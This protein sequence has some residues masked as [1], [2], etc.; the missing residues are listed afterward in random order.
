MNKTFSRACLAILAWIAQ[1]CCGCGPD[2]SITVRK[3]WEM[4]VWKTAPDYVQGSAGGIAI[5][6]WLPARIFKNATSIDVF[7][8]MSCNDK[9][10]LEKASV[11]VDLVLMR[12]RDSAVIRRLAGVKPQ[13]REVSRDDL[14][15]FVND[16]KA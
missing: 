3:E 1:V 6:A 13:F 2:A 14:S 7:V 15:L 11:T 9:S 4:N 5:E 12:T 16:Y 8:R 10:V